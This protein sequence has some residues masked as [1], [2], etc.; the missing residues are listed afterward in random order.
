V[1]V[2][3]RLLVFP[4]VGL[5][6]TPSRGR[7]ACSDPAPGSL[8]GL[9]LLGCTRARMRGHHFHAATSSA[10]FG[11][12]GEHLPA[13]RPRSSPG[14]CW[15]HRGRCHC[16]GPGIRRFGEAASASQAGGHLHDRVGDPGAVPPNLVCWWLAETIQA[17]RSVSAVAGGDGLAWA[18]D[19]WAQSTNARPVSSGLGAGRTKLG[20]G[21]FGPPSTGHSSLFVLA[22]RVAG[23][24]CSGF[25]NVAVGQCP[26]WWRGSP[27]QPCRSKD[28]RGEPEKKFDIIGR[29]CAAGHYP[30]FWAVIRSVR[31]RHNPRRSRHALGDRPCTARS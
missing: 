9:V 18:L 15:L 2:T 4:G 30:G 13:H 3:K 20:Q 27:L 16:A 21:C 10:P 23:K 14:I 11:N 7:R 12:Y 8:W 25:Q 28:R 22:D 31:E 6:G 1:Q 24:T 29:A 19:L 26:R 17:W 5:D